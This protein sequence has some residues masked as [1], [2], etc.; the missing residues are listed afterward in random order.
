M[1][2]RQTVSLLALAAGTTISTLAAQSVSPNEV[3]FREAR[4]KEQ[5]EGDL[6][7]AMKIYQALASA[8]G[9]RS[10]AAKALLQLGVCYEKQ[11][12]AEARKAYEKVLRSF[13]DQ[14]DATRVARMRLAR[15]TGMP[16]VA[17]DVT[18]RRL[19]RPISSFT[20]QVRTVSRDGAYSA[21][22][23][24]RRSIP[25]LVE[26]RTGSERDLGTGKTP[27]IASGELSSTAAISPDGSSVA[28]NRVRDDW[29]SEIHI[30]GVNSPEP[31]VLYHGP[32][33]AHILDWSRDGSTLLVR[34]VRTA[35]HQPLR[36]LLISARTG[37]VRELNL[38]VGRFGTGLLTEAE[39][40]Q[41]QAGLSPDARFVAYT[42]LNERS[43]PSVYV[44]PAD[45]S[46]RRRVT[47]P[48]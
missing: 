7:G 23:Y 48:G 21:Y 42:E 4:H 47:A 26:L 36:W 10:L 37:E 35:A 27:L 2:I 11:S 3:R 44:A 34:E 30:I 38:P 1:K 40:L 20:G 32:A 9:D 39:L 13:R 46:S 43:E 45:G 16:G 24:D 18:A 28:Y 22:V 5:V 14:D 15:L 31:K 17:T 8:K 12:S 29:T 41:L 33:A 6:N 19:S 25:V